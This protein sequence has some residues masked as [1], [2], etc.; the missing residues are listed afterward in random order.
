MLQI[1]ASLFVTFFVVWA[2]VFILSRIFWKPM[3][4]TTAER[5]ARLAD[6]REA[7]RRGLEA[8]DKSLQDVAAALKAARL[9]ADKA[10]ED[11]EAEALRREDPA[12]GR[13]RGFVQ[14]AG[15]EGQG[16]GPGRDRPPEIRACRPGRAAG[17]RHREKAARLMANRKAA[18][19]VLL[20]VPFLLAMSAEGEAHEAAASG[21]LGKIINFVVLFGALT[22][23]LYKPARNFLAKRTRDIQASL[24]EARNARTEAEARLEEAR[25]R[26][27][28]L[29]DEIAG[30]GRAAAAEGLAEKE[31]IKALAA[32]EA[33]RIRAFT[34]QEIDLQLKAGRSGAQGIHGRPGRL[35]GRSPDEGPDHARGPVRPD[36]QIHRTSRGA[37]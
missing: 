12:P 15:R 30:F 9:S 24:D 13:G 20:L 34:Q 7:S 8:Y 25:R 29:E 11:V 1:D 17:R 31:R 14:R 18:L 5:D 2:L 35:A 33:L 3:V 32:K 37:P 23:V 19:A 6:D 36:R 28:S 4:R 21:M 22:F 10:R 26:I 27:A 16:R